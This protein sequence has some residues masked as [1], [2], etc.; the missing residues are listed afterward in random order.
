[1]THGGCV[2][3]IHLERVCAQLWLQYWNDINYR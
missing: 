3:M 2:A 1:M